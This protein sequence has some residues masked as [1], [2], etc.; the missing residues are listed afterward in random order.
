MKTDEAVI[1]TREEALLFCSVHWEK[2][3]E[4]GWHIGLTGSVLYKGHSSK[5]LD[6]IFYPRKTQQK[7]RQKLCALLELLGWKREKDLTSLSHE[8]LDLKHVELWETAE[9]NRVDIFILQ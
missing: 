7:D 8:R 6:L 5:D 9:G 1:W 3:K 2:F 4:I